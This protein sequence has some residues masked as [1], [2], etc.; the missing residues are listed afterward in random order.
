MEDISETP[1]KDIDPY[2]TLDLDPSASATDIRTAYRKLA[3]KHHP[4]KASASEKSIAHTTFQNIAFAYAILSSPHR[5][6]LYDTTGSTSET[7]AQDDD[8]DF[9]WLSFFR[10]QFSS[11]SADT[12]TTFSASYK[13]SEKEKADL[14]AAYKKH[15]GNLNRVYEEVMLSNPLDDE[16]RFRRIIDEAIKAGEV[17]DY[18]AY[19]KE[20]KKSKDAR[21]K[22]ARREAELAGNEKTTNKQYQSIFG[23]D[24][25]GGRGTSLAAMI[26]SRQQER[27]D[28]FFDR[29]EVKYGR[30]GATADKTAGTGRKR[31]AQDEPSEEAFDK[32]RVKMAKAKSE[33][34]GKAKP[35]G[36]VISKAGAKGRDGK[37]KATVVEDE[38]VDGED[39]EEIDLEQESDGKEGESD[40]EF[41]EEPE[42]EVKPKRK[43]PASKAKKAMAPAAKKNAKGR[44]KK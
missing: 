19:I 34:E 32:A 33:R 18:D 25:K 21:M 6:T 23:G 10:D 43:A 36:K 39:D 30:G 27:Q 24:G 17:K 22:K 9:N 31:K 44:L 8:D 16:D 13:L 15:K 40:V 28:G 12:F 2:S 5:R 11:I 41:A 38:D 35:N 14:L 1:P 7:L 42:E 29:L 20:T 4:D 37:A 3:L 26:Q